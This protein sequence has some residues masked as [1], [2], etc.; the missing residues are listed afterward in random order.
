MG[1]VARAGGGEAGGGPVLAVLCSD[2]VGST[3]LYA[4]LGDVAAHALIADHDEVIRQVLAAHGGRRVKGLGDGVLAVFDSPRA[5]I[6]AALEVQGATDA[7]RVEADDDAGGPRLALRVGLSAGEV[8]EDD[9]G[10]VHGAAVVTAARITALATGGQVLA[11]EVVVRLAGRMP[12]LEVRSLGPRRLKGF[13]HSV[14]LCDVRVEGTRHDTGERTALVPPAPPHATEDEFVGRGWERSEVDGS[15][16]ATLAGRGALVLVSGEAGIGKTRLAREATAGAANRGCRTIWAECWEGDGPAY[17]PWVQVLRSLRDALDWSSLDRRA[18]G[19]LVPEFGDDVGL[20]AEADPAGTRARVFNAVVDLF[21]AASAITPLVVVL[22]DLHWAD[23]PSLL[24]LRYLASRLPAQA[25]LILGTYRDGEVAADETLAGL[26]SALGRNARTLRLAGLSAEELAVLVTAATGKGASKAWLDVLAE[27]TS[28]NPLFAKEVL[29]LLV[30]Q[31]GSAGDSLA[32]LPPSV[33][34]VVGRRVARLPQEVNIVLEV[35]AVLGEQF[36][37]GDIAA[38]TERGVVFGAL[39]IAARAG[40][41]RPTG[42]GF[43]FTH[44]LV[45]EALY[46]GLGPVRRATLHQEVGLALESSGAPAE[47]LARH[48]IAAVPIAGA[49]QAVRYAVAAG[50]AALQH[51]AH[52]EALTWFNRALEMATDDGEPI[53]RARL[54]RAEARRRAGEIAEA[55]ADLDHVAAASRTNAKPREFARAALGIHRLGYHS[56]QLH[57]EAIELL[58]DAARALAEDNLE[59]RA[60]VLS[61]LAIELW[62]HARDR[63]DEARARSIE[64]L[65]LAERLGSPSVLARCLEARYTI[66]W[67]PGAGPE[68]AVIAARMGELARAS[69]NGEL[70]ATALLLEATALLEMGDPRGLVVLERFFEQGTALRLAKLDYQVRTRQAA[71]AMLRGDLDAAGALIDESAELAAQ[72][73]EPDAHL[74]EKHQRGEQLRFELRRHELLDLEPFPT[75]P[76]TGSLFGLVERPVM[77]LD[78]GRREEARVLVERASAIPLDD[79]KRDWIFVHNVTELAEAAVRLEDHDVAARCYRALLPYAGT[80]CLVSALVCFSGAVDHHLGIL[81]N[82]L[83][84]G[85][86]AAGHLEAALEIHERLGARLWVKASLDLLAEVRTKSAAGPFGVPAQSRR[87]G[88]RPRPGPPRAEDT[89]QEP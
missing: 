83:G 1:A 36:A 47:V 89:A 22:D 30:S 78:G 88:G 81:A 54:G 74:I 19:M 70:H 69:G 41:V 3:E 24:L 4:S 38:T 31:G 52:E 34:D 45:R 40:L 21:G 43:A 49:E 14:E 2:I 58:E 50:E 13:D 53:L 46:E 11:A 29:R 75:R 51:L 77:L 63:V 26:F 42:D 7:A 71:L 39:D 86:A 16:D 62:N 10:D 6:R 59:L 80:T 8:I 67:T 82:E 85:A 60:P 61:A 17:W 73:G 37:V 20:D 57:E 25:V 72:I 84:D 18:L 5:A 33:V 32:S 55:R 68:R 28:G 23:E 48:F 56:G 64:A 9:E 12:G 79:V 76:I 35:A 44:A 87:R 66:E 65:G 15:L 27:R